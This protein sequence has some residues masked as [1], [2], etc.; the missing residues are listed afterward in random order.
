MQ[1]KRHVYSQD[2][3]FSFSILTLGLTLW[4]NALD[5]YSTLLMIYTIIGSVYNN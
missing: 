2:T 5:T 4:L 1:K 3:V